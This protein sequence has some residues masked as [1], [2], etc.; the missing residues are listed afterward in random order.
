MN[1][2]TV[3]CPH[4][5]GRYRLKKPA[6]TE[7]LKISKFKCGKCVKNFFINFKKISP[8]SDLVYRAQKTAQEDGD[9]V[10]NIAE[11]VKLDGEKVQESYDEIMQQKR[12]LEAVTPPQNSAPP[13]EKQEEQPQEESSG[14]LDFDFDESLFDDGDFAGNTLSSSS[15]SSF[16]DSLKNVFSESSSPSSETSTSEANSFSDN[17]F[18]SETTSEE[19]SDISEQAIDEPASS[20]LFDSDTDEQASSS[21]FDSGNDEQAS[22]SLFDSGNDEQAPTNLFDSG[23]EQAPASLFDSG[24]DEPF[25]ANLFDSNNDEQAPANLFDSGNDS[26]GDSQKLDLDFLKVP[27]EGDVGTSNIFDINISSSPE[28]EETVGSSTVE[29]DI[30]STSLWKRAQ[31]RKESAASKPVISEENLEKIKSLSEKES[32]FILK[33]ALNFDLTES[34]QVK[35]VLGDYFEGKQSVTNPVVLLVERGYITFF[36]YKTLAES[37][38]K[39]KNAGRLNSVEISSLEDA[40][41]FL[42]FSENRKAMRIVCPHCK[43]SYRVKVAVKPGK[44]KCGKC[45]SYFFLTGK[46]A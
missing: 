14:E 45:K 34:E 46:K 29:L 15:G 8:E 16:E 23:N 26:R 3:E 6:N 20:S 7:N 36:Q 21:L 18:D 19:S 10:K 17:L 5:T 38:E 31:A 37:L 1:L 42:G 43:S 9:E 24:N 39:D 25:S 35:E 44:F 30:R 2:V 12:R 11:T 27:S 4:C 22:S 40:E 28:P 13:E 33:H 41:V 32:I